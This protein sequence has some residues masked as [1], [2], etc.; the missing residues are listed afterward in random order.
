MKTGNTGARTKERSAAA[1][2]RSRQNQRRSRARRKEYTQQLEERLRS[3]ERL[4]VAASQEVQETGRKVAKENALLR[5]LLILHGVSKEEIKKYL[6]S[7]ATYIPSVPSSAPTTLHSPIAPS[8]PLINCR[9][10]RIAPTLELNSSP[11]ELDTIGTQR[12]P[13]KSGTKGY[14]GLNIQGPS[15]ERPAALSSGTPET[16]SKAPHFA[17]DRDIGQLTSCEKAARIIASLRDYPDVHDLRSELGCDSESNCM[18]KN[19][20]IFDVLDK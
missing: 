12:S 15:A 7:E 20:S 5:S 13:S 11:R 4:G 3:F 18:V 16:V 6:E 9:H 19:M 8:D 1:L 14:I 10:A 17:G 2:A